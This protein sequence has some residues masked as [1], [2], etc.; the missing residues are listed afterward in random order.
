MRILYISALPKTNSG[1]PKHSVPKQ[2]VSQAAFDEVSWINITPWGVENTSVKCEII[3]DLKVIKNEIVK[4]KTELVVFEDLHYIKFCQIGRF[5]EKKK[6]PYI[7]VP[8]GCLTEAA[9]K[10]KYL[11]K[12]VAHLL[13]FNHFVK[14]AVAIEYLTKAEEIN[15]GR[16]WNK[17][18]IIVPNGTD[19]RAETRVF[20]DSVNDHL[21]GTFIGRINRYHKGIDLFLD[22]CGNLKELIQ[23]R[24][25]I[26]DFYG[27]YLQ[28]EYEEIMKKITE[29]GLTDRIN[30]HREIHNEEK[31]KVLLNSDFFILT[32]RFEG[33]PMGLLEALSYGVPALVTDETN[34]GKEIAQAGAGFSS[35]CAVDGITENFKKFLSMDSEQFAE[36]GTNA[37]NFSKLYNWENIAKDCHKQYENLLEGKNE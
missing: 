12:K 26:M 21:Q 23:K 5:L 13:L 22:A 11:K 8:R 37:V 3:D 9:Q 19:S 27:P 4:R 29:V 7:I 2:V 31:A 28:E 10:Q 18:S 1:G 33:L 24:N 32:S 35:P 36:L 30:I 25:L 16:K 17:T 14:K 15:S 20:S 6:I 34:I